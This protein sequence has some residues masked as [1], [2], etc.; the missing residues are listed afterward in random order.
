M[1]SSWK[2]NKSIEITLKTDIYMVAIAVLILILGLITLFQGYGYLVTA[3]NMCQD[4]INP[5]PWVV[6]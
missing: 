1:R 3:V 6:P 4:N 5:I 2:S